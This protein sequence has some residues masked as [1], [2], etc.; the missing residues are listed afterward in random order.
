MRRWVRRRLTYANVASTLAVFLVLGGGTAIA[1]YVVSDN[2]QIGPGTV[3]GHNPPNGD[4]ANVIKG[5]INATDLAKNAVTAAELGAAKKFR[6]V[7][8]GS[9]SPKQILSLGGL[10]LTYRCVFDA[11]E[12]VPLVMVTT[13]VNHATITRG[14]MIGN[15]GS[16]TAFTDIDKDFQTTDQ[17]DLTHDQAFGEGTAVYSAPNGSVV[18]LDFGFQSSPTGCLAHGLALAR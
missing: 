4:H 15:A 17:F 10:T 6:E 7:G 9:P 1:A 3:S 16:G 2:S 14:L 11:A 5:S 18:M 12:Y 8:V 13:S